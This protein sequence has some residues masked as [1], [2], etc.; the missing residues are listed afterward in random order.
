[1]RHSVLHRSDAV[2]LGWDLGARNNFQIEVGI[3]NL[4]WGLVAGAAVAWS[5]G[6][7]AQAAITLVFAGYLLGAFAVHVVSILDTSEQRGSA[8]W[9][10]ALATLAFSVGLFWFAIA[11]LRA[12]GLS[13]VG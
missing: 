6:A 13:P 3:A 5:W 9:P 7:A 12:A 2:R 4:C 11:G 10:P 8:G 1:V